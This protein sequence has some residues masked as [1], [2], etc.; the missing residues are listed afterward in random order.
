MEP[1]PPNT[2][3]T[4]YFKV[5]G[6]PS[7]YPTQVVEAV[8]EVVEGGCPAANF[9]IEAYGDNGAVQRLPRERDG[10]NP[11]REQAHLAGARHRRF[12]DLPTWRRADVQGSPRRPNVDKERRWM[13]P[14]SISA[15]DEPR[16][17]LLT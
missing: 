1:A 5:V 8:L 3:G 6:S 17:C 10:A 12:P 14:Q 7:L 11:G 16:R 13:V 9:F 4:S 15:S 2:E